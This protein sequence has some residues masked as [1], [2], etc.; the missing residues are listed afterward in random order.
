MSC[1]SVSLESLAPPVL[2][3]HEMYTVG[4]VNFAYS[5][6]LCWPNSSLL[7]SPLAWIRKI[8]KVH[9]KIINP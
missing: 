3:Q 2:P 5:T 1:R 4:D 6:N 9:R 7:A 8:Q